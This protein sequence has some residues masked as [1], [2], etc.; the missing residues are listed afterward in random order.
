MCC[1]HNL[2]PLNFDLLKKN[3]IGTPLNFKLNT[4][5]SYF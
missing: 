1:G 5:I 4:T 2:L 3:L